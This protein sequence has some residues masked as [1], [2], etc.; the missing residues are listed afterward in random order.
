[1]H[2]MHLYHT[3]YALFLENLIINACYHDFK[4]FKMII[5]MFKRIFF[6]FHKLLT[7]MNI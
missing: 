4:W 1:M 5:F 6:I 2:F 7:F 3:F